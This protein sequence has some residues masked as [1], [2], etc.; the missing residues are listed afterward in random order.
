MRQALAEADH[1]AEEME[2]PIGAVVVHEGRII[3]RGRN[4][5]IGATDPTAHA[6][7]VA[8][9]AGALSLQNYRLDGCTLYVTVEPCPMCMGAAIWGRVERIVYGAGDAKA[10]AAGSVMDLSR[11]PQFN[12]SIT[13][14][15]GL[16][17]A[18]CRAQMERF[19]QML[20]KAKN[21]N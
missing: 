4:R 14:S 6:E 17:E 11:V 18:D 10:E 16:L 20:R 19:F 5:T 7:I 15:R 9:G 8:I 21:V 2:V 12:H 13:I 1:A 3:G